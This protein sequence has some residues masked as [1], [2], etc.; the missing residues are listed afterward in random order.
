MARFRTGSAVFKATMASWSEDRVPRLAAALAYYTLFSLAPLL[1]IVIAVASLVFGQQAAEGRIADQIQG[2]L[3]EEGAKAV[4]AMLQH[5]GEQKATG[6]LATVIGVVTLV[7]GASGVFGELQDALNT[8]WRVK[9]RPGRGV[10][11]MV[12][13][14]FFSFAMV[15]GIVFLLLVSLVVSAALAALGKFGSRMIP[16]SALHVLDIVVSVAVVTVLFAMI[17]KIMPDVRIAWRDVW[18]GALFTAVLFTVGKILIGLYLGRSSVGSAFGAA[19]SLVVVLVWLYYSAQIL[20]LG[21]EL[22]KAY[23]H[24]RTPI[25]QPTADAMPVDPA[26]PRADRAA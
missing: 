7:F 25:V 15:L 3:G 13:A 1:I 16:V 4:Q 6:I 18:V 24:R 19:G 12:R 9:P 21:A 23:A 17:F 11:D 8:I 22:T 5:A 26:R 10:F 20:F 2:L 14:R